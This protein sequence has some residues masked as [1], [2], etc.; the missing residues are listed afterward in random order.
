MNR[1]KKA[2]TT[3]GLS[4]GILVGAVVAAP[5]ATAAPAHAVTTTQ[6]STKYVYTAGG[7]YSKTRITTCYYD[8]NWWE[9]TFQGQRDGWYSTYVPIYT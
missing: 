3:I 2:F 7:S 9:E 5:V 4:V 8:Y 6:C 1:V